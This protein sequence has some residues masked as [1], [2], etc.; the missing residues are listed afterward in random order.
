MRIRD[1]YALLALKNIAWSPI[2]VGII[3][4]G[5]DRQHVEFVGVNTG[6][7]SPTSPSDLMNHGTSVAGII[8]ANNLGLSQDCNGGNSMQMNGIVAGGGC[9]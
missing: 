3:D 7:Q 5:I 6:S 4:S 2:T 9:K 1:V 8:G